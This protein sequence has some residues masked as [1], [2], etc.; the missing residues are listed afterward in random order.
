V[1]EP[2]IGKLH[3]G[4]RVCMTCRFAQIVSCGF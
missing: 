2:R 1:E 3:A 4:L